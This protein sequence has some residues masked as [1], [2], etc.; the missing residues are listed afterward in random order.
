MLV[1]TRRSGEAIVIDGSIRIQVLRTNGSR[2]RLG[3]E[4]PPEVRIIREK[5]EKAPAVDPMPAR[6]GVLRDGVSRNV[7]AVGREVRETVP[8]AR[9]PGG[10]DRHTALE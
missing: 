4:A 1:L 3:I 5:G 6:R 9:Q 8:P 7:A 10:V 2:V